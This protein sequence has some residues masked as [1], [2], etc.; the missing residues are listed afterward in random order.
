MN[1]DECWSII[2]DVDVAEAVEWLHEGNKQWP[3]TSR[4]GKPQRIHKLPDVCEALVDA[5]ME[6]CPNA[7]A[8]EKMLSRMLP[9][10]SHSMHDDKQRSGWIT[11]VHVPLVTNGSAWL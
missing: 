3:D 8:Q 6:H 11:R 5:V 9:G 2:C 4:P 10:Q 1:L 7:A